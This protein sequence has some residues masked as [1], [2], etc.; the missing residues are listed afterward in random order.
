MQCNIWLTNVPSD[1][2]VTIVSIGFITNVSSW[3][4]FKYHTHKVD[5]R[6]QNVNRMCH[7]NYCCTGVITISSFIFNT[8]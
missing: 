5:K 2:K 1:Y 3:R 8:L 4:F 7:E 6:L